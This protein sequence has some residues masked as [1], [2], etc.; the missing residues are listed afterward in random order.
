MRPD[1]AAAGIA[2]TGPRATAL[3]V[4]QLRELVAA[5]ALPGA[6]GR[7]PRSPAAAARDALVLVLGWAMMARRGELCALNL[8]DVAEVTCGLEVLVRR[9]KNDQSATG[10][11]VAL[12]HGRDPRTCPVLAW[13]AWTGLLAE[14]EITT[15]AV[16]RRFHRSGRI[17]DRLSEQSLY[18]IVTDAAERAGRGG[19]PAARSARRWRDWG[20]P[21]RCGRAADRVAWA[22]ARRVPD[23][24]GLPP[25]HRPVGPQP[26]ARQRSVAGPVGSQRSWHRSGTC[27]RSVRQPFCERVSLSTGLIL[28]CMGRSWDTKIQSLILPG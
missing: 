27:A 7:P 25:R 1:D 5:C 17:G 2:N 19:H 9:S 23:G 15:G 20:L 12:P 21:G 22:M 26:D 6:P 16:F 13:R 11:F 28:S 8:A 10:H 14:Q 3:S 18:N 24:A 4:P